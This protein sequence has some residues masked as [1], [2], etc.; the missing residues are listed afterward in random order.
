MCR[1]LQGIWCSSVSNCRHCAHAICE[2]KAP[3][4]N[5][6]TQVSTVSGDAEFADMAAAFFDSSPQPAQQAPQHPA[7]AWPPPQQAQQQHQAL[8]NQQQQRHLQ[9][10]QQ[11]GMSGGPHPQGQAGVYAQAGQQYSTARSASQQQVGQ[12]LRAPLVTQQQHYHPGQAAGQYP[13]QA[14]GQSAGQYPGQVA[15]HPAGQYPG[16]A[17][18]QHAV[19]AGSQQQRPGHYPGQQQQHPG[20]QQLHPGQPAGQ[21]AGQGHPGQQHAA[22]QAAATQETLALF[23]STYALFQQN[24][25]LVK[26]ALTEY[27]VAI[28]KGPSVASAVGEHQLVSP[29]CMQWSMLSC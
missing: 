11:M 15:G 4:A 6:Y 13:G 8:L 7:A 22:G 14:S 20:Q 16:Q 18:G 23:Q 27:Q 28:S 25:D 17:A 19:T 10:Q 5:P 9:Q 12:P 24:V 3:I 1:Q 29:S 21:A 2:V 26:A